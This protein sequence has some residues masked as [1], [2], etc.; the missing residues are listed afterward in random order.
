MFIRVKEVSK[1]VDING[2]LLG[3]RSKGCKDTAH[4]SSNDVK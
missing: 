2:R 4:F 1:Y 3:R